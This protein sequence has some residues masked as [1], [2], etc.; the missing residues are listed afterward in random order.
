MDLMKMVYIII[1]ITISVIIAA[2]AFNLKAHIS[3]T[4]DSFKLGGKCVA[5]RDNR[6]HQ[7]RWASRRQCNVVN[8]DHSGWNTYHHCNCYDGS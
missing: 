7:G 2:K 8:S 6:S 3:T 1:G 5:A 4:V